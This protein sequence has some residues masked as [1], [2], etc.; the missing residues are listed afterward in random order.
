MLAVGA[1]V[2]WLVWSWREH[3]SGLGGDGWFLI[4][5]AGWDSIT[6]FFEREPFGSSG[7]GYGAEGPLGGV[8]DVHTSPG[9]AIVKVRTWL[10]GSAIV[11]PLVLFVALSYRGL[12]RT[13]FPLI[14]TDPSR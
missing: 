6:F 14:E 2:A 11:T 9:G 4:A 1:V 3:R 8:L 7:F 10:F 12:R 5:S 13:G